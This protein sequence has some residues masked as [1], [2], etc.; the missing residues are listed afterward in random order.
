MVDL[1]AAFTPAQIQ[2]LTALEQAYALL[3]VIAAA[4]NVTLLDAPAVNL[5]QAQL[6]PDRPLPG[7]Q[8]GV[9]ISTG[10]LVFTRDALPN[11]APQP[12]R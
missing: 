6:I 7:C 8:L 4:D 2:K 9:T 10:N 11:A 12:A 1:R 5:G 3:P